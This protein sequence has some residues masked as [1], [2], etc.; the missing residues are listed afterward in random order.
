V[1]FGP[2]ARAVDAPSALAGWTPEA[3]DHSLALG[4]RLARELAGRTGMLMVVSDVAPASRGEA[5]FEGGLWVSTGE[6]LTNI[7]ITSAQRT[8]SLDDGSGA[9]ALTIANNADTPAR[10][11]LAILAGDKEVLAR[12]LDVPPGTS[13]L[14]LP[15]PASLPA[16]RVS[17]SDDSLRRDNAVMLAAPR[18]RLVA[19]ENHLPDGR[20]RQALA[21]ALD[22]LS[23]V[24]HAQSGHLAFVDA[25]DLERAREPGVWRVAFGRPPA[26]WL[27]AGEPR[28]FIGPFVLEKRHPLLLGVTLDGVIWSGASPVNAGAIRPLVSTDDRMLIGLA[29]AAAGAPA[30]VFNLDLDRTNLIRAPDWPILMSNLVELRRQA[31]PGPERWNYRAG[32]WVR[33]RLDRDPNGPLSFRCGDIARTLPGGRHVEFVAP[34]PCELLQ[35]LEG[36]DILF[37][38]GVNFL[39][40]SETSLRNQMTADAGALA[41][42][43][44]LRAE[45]GRTSDPLFWILLVLAVVAVMANWCLFLPQPSRA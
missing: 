4:L 24:T 21:R 15:L 35:I 43:P 42:V 13:S 28:D 33:A 29:D 1:L 23:G 40:E 6:P 19:V 12:E 26:T 30:I 34:S 31:L 38:I 20:G 39:D 36:A 44:A 2:A 16:V 37:E 32:E 7:G 3:P 9:V 41:D 45:T 22:V 11:R 17:L 27:T 25:A 5:H 14:T 10:R 8:F 18:P